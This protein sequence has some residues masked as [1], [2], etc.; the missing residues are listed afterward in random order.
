MSRLLAALV[1][2]PFLAGGVTAALTADRGE[3]VLTF[4]DPEVVESSGLVVRDGL[5]EE[6]DVLRTPQSPAG[7]AWLNGVPAVEAW[8]M[9]DEGK[10]LNDL[11]DRWGRA[12]AA[13]PGLFAREAAAGT[14]ASQGGA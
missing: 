6:M 1:A 7:I 9:L 12:A 13:L 5:L 10:S 8:R 3:V 4:T 2:L 14:V 11:V